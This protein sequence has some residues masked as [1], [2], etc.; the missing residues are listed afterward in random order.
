M[1][2]LISALL[3]SIATMAT[4]QPSGKTVD[5][6]ENPS[7]PCCKNWATYMEKNGFQVRVH[8][9]DDINISRQKLGM[10]QKYGSCHTAVIDG[11]LIEGHVP[12]SDIKRLLSEKP[13]A[14]GLAVPGMVVGSPGMEGPNPKPYQTLIIKPDG[15]SSV[16]ASH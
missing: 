9:V 8:N 16:F 10:P 2:L 14:V 13:K 6:Y 15:V 1:K 3:F 12:V 11:Y 4:A 5:M 7:C